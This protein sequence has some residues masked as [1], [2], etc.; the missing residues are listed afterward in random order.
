[1]ARLC[2]LLGC[3][4]TTT[5]AHHPTGNA[6][7]ERLW[8]WV[9]SCLRQ[10]TK[11]QYEH[12][13]DYVRLMEHTWNTANHSILKCS[14]FEAAHGLP[15][16]S[17]QD[18]WVEELGKQNT[19]LMIMEGVEAMRVTAKAF[20]KQIR[21]VRQQAAEETARYKRK[22]LKKTYEVGQQLSLYLPP[23]EAEAKAMG[24]KPKHM[25]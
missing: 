25:L 8:Q 1:M 16:R 20:E 2:N 23:S 19:D 9:A 14:P 15:P 5:L 18:S 24:R 12:W 10:M 6:T 4:Q 13:E 3:K 17:V 7:I 22:G 11:E 21:N